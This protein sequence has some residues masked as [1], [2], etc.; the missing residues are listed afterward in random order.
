MITPI[1][2]SNGYNKIKPAV[3]LCSE[4]TYKYCTSTT[5]KSIS[6]LKVGNMVI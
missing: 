1:D 2:L 4:Y 3:G 6:L 5:D